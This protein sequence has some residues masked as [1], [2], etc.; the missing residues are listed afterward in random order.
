VALVDPN[1]GSTARGCRAP[2]IEAQV[3]IYPP[4][5]SRGSSL[6]T[7]FSNPN[8][9]AILVIITGVFECYW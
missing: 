9:I 3:L 1:Y 4:R 8:A 7:T 5:S 6:F 2:G